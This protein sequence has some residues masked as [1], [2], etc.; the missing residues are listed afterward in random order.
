MQ[1]AAA[2]STS[3]A[4]WGSRR[5]SSSAVVAAR[6]LNA[7]SLAGSGARRQLKASVQC[8]HP[9]KHSVA[10]ADVLGMGL[11][12]GFGSG[13]RI[14]KRATLPVRA[15]ASGISRSAASPIPGCSLSCWG[16]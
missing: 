14:Q 5:P 11:E 16:G 10:S 3:S 6:S 13:A 12:A 8:A 4:A 2:P 7:Q 1:V 15:Q 9:L